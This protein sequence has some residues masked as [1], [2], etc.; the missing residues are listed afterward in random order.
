MSEFSLM[1]FHVGRAVFAISNIWLMYSFLT[2]KRPWWFQIIAFVGTVAAHLFLR[3]LLTPMGLDPYLIGYILALL[4][5]VPVALVFKET[6][7]TKFFIVFM[8][9]CFSHFNYIFCLFLEQLLFGHT[10]SILILPGQLLELAAIPLIRR[11][12]T[13][14]IKTMLEILDQQ[15]RIFIWFPFLSYLLF[16]YY[17]IQRQYLLSVFIPLVLSTIIIFIAYYLIAIAIAQTKC[18]QQLEQQLALQRDHYRN[19]ND[20]IQETR[21]IRHDMRHHLVMLLEFLG[22]NDAAAAQEYLNKLCNF[23]DDSSLPTVCRNQLADA[24]V[25]HYLKLA[26]QKEINFVTNLY[27]PDDPGIHDLDLC[28]II[29]NCLENAFE[30]CCKLS[31]AKLRF[32]D[33]KATINKG[34]LVITIANS[35]NGLSNQQGDHADSSKEGTEHGIGLNSVKTLAAKYQGNCS[36]SVEEHVFTVFISLKIPER[37]GGVVKYATYSGVR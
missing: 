3:H 27:I 17:G 29:G 1:L 19:L 13:P 20:S 37:T 32:I 16:A 11:Y 2:S 31:D 9:V 28:V 22:K 26:K 36:V 35:F 25:C 12:I 6:I 5:L 10:V 18:H 15:N 14:H 4:Y 30:A 8:V 23:Y 21:V 7:H 33:I 34:Y 24:L